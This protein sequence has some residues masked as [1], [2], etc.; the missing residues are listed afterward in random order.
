MGAEASWPRS[1][2]EARREARRERKREVAR[3]IKEFRE[4]I[5]SSEPLELTPQAL[6]HWNRDDQVAALVEGRDSEPD[7]GFMMRLLALCSCRAPTRVS[8]TA[9]S[10]RTDPTL[11]S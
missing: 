3:N 10:G 8:K 5:G 11:W 9:T 4:R 2:D 6:H 7:T 1:D